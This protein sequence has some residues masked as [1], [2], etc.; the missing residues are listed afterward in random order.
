MWVATKLKTNYRTHVDHL[1]Y[2]FF[3][4]LIQLSL[5]FL[6]SVTWNN[7]NSAYL[8]NIQK[9]WLY[10]KAIELP[11]KIRYKHRRSN[12]FNIVYAFRLST[13]ILSFLAHNFEFFS[14]RVL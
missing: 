2:I 4:I 1:A 14:D 12:S 7:E 9:Q 3:Y 11:T 6:L 13:K 8:A 5:S 10:P